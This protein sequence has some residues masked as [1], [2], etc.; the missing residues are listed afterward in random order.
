MSLRLCFTHWQLF[1]ERNGNGYEMRLAHRDPPRIIDSSLR[2][3]DNWVNCHRHK[4]PAWALA[5]R[6][7]LGGVITTATDAQEVNNVRL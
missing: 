5:A 4:P 3:G 2:T 7:L 6:E 1:D